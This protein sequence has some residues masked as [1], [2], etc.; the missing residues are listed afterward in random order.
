V[1]IQAGAGLETDLVHQYF[2]YNTGH[3]TYT[4]WQYI[5][6]G[7]TGDTY[8]ILLNTYAQPSTFNWSVQIGFDSATGNYHCDC[9]MHPPVEGPF[10]YD[11]WVEIRAEIYLDHDWVQVYYDGE[12][13]DN[14]LV[15]DHPILGGGYI[16]TKGVF[17]TDPAGQLNIA[18]V[19]LY[20]NVA[21][22]DGNAY[23]DDMTLEPGSGT[24][25]SMGIEPDTLSASL[26]GTV[27]LHMAAGAQNAFRQYLVLG[28]VSGTGPFLLPGSVPLPITFDLFTELLID[29]GVPPIGSLDHLGAGSTSIFFPPF[30]IAFP[31]NMYFAFCC[32]YKPPTGW[33]G[34]TGVTLTINP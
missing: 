34:S 29:L 14:P 30:T 27:T 31:F 17:G 25:P 3:W 4:A 20:G 6:T 9:G 11:Q 10:I 33:Y 7:Y 12:L 28:S 16:W 26:G 21:G 24:V 23:Y 2:G 5:P 8:F 32:P 19:D 15:A 1:E 18:A 22:G 13:I